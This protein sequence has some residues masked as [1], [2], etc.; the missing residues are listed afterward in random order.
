MYNKNYSTPIDKAFRFK[1]FVDNLEKITQ[2]NLDFEKG[3]VTFRLGINQFSDMFAHEVVAARNGFDGKRS[4]SNTS[5]TF[6]EPEYLV[7]PDE[8]DWSNKGAVTPVKDQGNYSKK[9]FLCFHTNY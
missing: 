2:H 7:M 9:S 6:I 1:I 3:K 4:I 5:D 8:V